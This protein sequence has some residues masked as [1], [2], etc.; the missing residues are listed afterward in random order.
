VAD[1]I[2]S[3]PPEG[4][5][6]VPRGIVG[7][8]T[9]SVVDA[10]EMVDTLAKLNG[11]IAETLVVTG[12]SRLSDARTPT[13]HTH[14]AS[15]L[16]DSTAAGRSMIT[17]ADAA[18][19]RTLLNVED[20]ATADQS[21]AEIETAYNNQVDVVSQLE[22]EAGTSTTPR[23]WTAARVKQAIDALASATGLTAADIDTLAELNAILTDAT[24]IDTTDA[25]LSDAR[26]PT[27]HNHPAT[28]ISD[29]TAAGRS[30]LTA[31]DAAAQRTL[32]NVEDGATADQS[33][34]EIVTAYG[35]EVDVVSQAEA[36]AGTVTDVRRWTPQRVKQAIDALGGGGAL[37]AA[38]IDTLAELNAILTDATLIDTTDARLSDA[39]TPTAHNHPATGISDSTAAGRSMLTAADAAAQRTLLNVE[40]GATADQTNAEIAAAYDAEIPVVSQVDAEAGTSTTA[41][42]W[43]PARVKQAID[44]LSPAAGG[45]SAA[46]IDTLAELNAILTDATL[47]DTTDARL[48][49]ARTPTAHNH[50]ATGISDSTAAG[51]S[52]LTAAD[53]AAQRTLLNVENGATADQSDAEIE[54]AY[55]NQVAAVTQGEAEAGT[56][57]AIKRWTP[58][59]V[60]QAIDALALQRAETT[61]AGRAIVAA[62]D[63]AAQR[64]LLNVED[65]ATA[66]QSDAEIETAYNNQVG[67]VSQAAA[68]AGTSTTAE[69]WTPE[70]VKQAID[71]LGV[72]VSGID[73]LAKLNAL[74]LDATLSDSTAAGRA[75][76]TAAD[77]AAQ[78]T[79]LNVQDGATADQTDAEIETAYNNQVGIVSQAAAEAGTSTTAERWT[80]QRVKQAV[81]ALALQSADINTLAKLN[82]IVADA[83]LSDSTAAGRALM[84]AADASAQRLLLN[85]SNGATPDQT[86]AEIETAYNN[87]VDEVSQ[88]EAEAGT[89]TTVRRWTALRVAQAIDALAPG[90]SG[91]L[92]AADIDTLAELNAILTDATLI[93]TADA[94][95]SDARTPTAHTHTASEVSDSTT[96]GR[97]MLTA[98][99]A[100]AQRTLLNVQDGATADQ[101]DVEIEAAYNNQVDVVSQAIAEAGS[102]T[103]V[104]RWTPERVKQAIDALSGGGGGGLVAA[105]IDTLAELN[106]ILTD[107]TLGDTTAAGRSI[108]AAAD[109]A[110][111]RT[112]LN[113]EDGATADQSDAEIETAYNNQVGI[114]SQ[115]AAEAGT[116]TTAERWT[117]QR[118]AQAID[119]LAVKPADIDT[120][121]ELNAILT[122]ATLGDTTAAGRA[123]MAAAD[124]AAQRTL[125]NVQD[126]ATADQSDA[127]IETA[128]DNQVGIVSQAEAEA[129]TATTVRRW[130]AER[131]SQ[132]IVT[133]STQFVETENYDHTSTYTY[134]GIDPASGWVINRYDSSGTKTQATESNNGGTTDLATAW[135]NRLTLNYG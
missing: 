35:N 104:Y 121:A 93:D 77:A 4:V 13:S 100:A 89:S 106:A 115:A 120:L 54:T 116:S 110:A 127:E 22:A 130:T 61:T 103:T 81:D 50:P 71:A 65:G 75:L 132:A 78:R 26:T 135:T 128:Y 114:V 74:V 8:S 52:M 7:N 19:Q 6:S 16:S 105:D 5:R 39:R 60:K 129:G 38:D 34:A 134:F 10:A 73:S 82:A 87:Q 109:A 72:S 46:D 49:D 32:L 11:A 59:R 29:S 3:I 62:A 108:M 96:A 66:D 64:V 107:A 131:V 117:P 43:T 84:T 9:G 31:A 15:E 53:A 41:G 79:L 2:F 47:I 112:L 23:R 111:Q 80:P 90:G 119:A 95:L 40:N 102:S 37:Q 91:T 44:A 68:E 83:T 97:S 98:A 51:R 101:S 70:R 118:V 88:A 17:A 42:R 57:G 125:L 86:D 20:G 30:M 67:I 33:D 25:R 85:V 122:D 12:D 69:R 113:V 124:A 55:N 28:G 76:M 18:A 1:V 48:S 45:L 133:Q 36:E 94:R 58:A 63:A 24:L 27:A 92:T 99:D 14:A 56:S 21:D 126:G 123:L